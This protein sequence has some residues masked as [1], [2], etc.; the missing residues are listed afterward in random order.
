MIYNGSKSHNFLIFRP[1]RVNLNFLIY[2]CTL[3]QVLQL[4]S[5]NEYCNF[6]RHKFRLCLLNYRQLDLLLLQT[7]KKLVF[8]QT[9][10]QFRFLFHL[11][12]CHEFWTLNKN[13]CYAPKTLM[14]VPNK[15]R[16][17]IAIKAGLYI[18]I[19]YYPSNLKHSQS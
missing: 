3:A 9:I 6:L 1:S 13:F 5:Y 17:G 4:C 12:I 2:L 7:V 16:T 15:H 11:L 10:N 8:V 19:H 18:I 14:G